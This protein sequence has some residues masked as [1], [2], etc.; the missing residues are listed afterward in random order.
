MAKQNFTEVVDS[1]GKREDFP[2]GSVRDTEDGKG[3]PCLIPWDTIDLLNSQKRVKILVGLNQGSCLSALSISLKNY[4][5]CRSLRLSQANIYHH[6]GIAFRAAATLTILDAG[7]PL[8]IDSFDSITYAYRRLSQHYQNGAR[9]YKTNNWRKGQPTSRYFNSCKR[10]VWSFIEGCEEEDHLAAILW[11]IVGMCR[12]HQDVTLG[13][14]DSKFDD[15]PF[16]EEQW[17]GKKVV[18][19][20]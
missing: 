18:D 1:G 16:T 9:K 17:F 3:S 2:S 15:F 8:L 13:L 14:L 5:C 7:E 4:S 11:N 19:D 12:T 20:S 10:H 6:L